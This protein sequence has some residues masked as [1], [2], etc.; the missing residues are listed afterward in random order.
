VA[1]LAGCSEE[2][3]LFWPTLRCCG[4]VFSPS[5]KGPDE[6]NLLRSRGDGGGEQGNESNVENE[7]SPPKLQ[8]SMS[9]VRIRVDVAELVFGGVCN[10]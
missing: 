5:T 3:V 4:V 2:T 6:T 8:G 9:M 1:R 7:L 10:G